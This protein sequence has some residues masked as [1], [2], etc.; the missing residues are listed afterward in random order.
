MN[1][2]RGG[3]TIPDQAFYRIQ[4]SDSLPFNNR[5]SINLRPNKETAVVSLLALR[6]IA[7]L[8]K[9]YT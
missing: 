5:C 8:N 9:K 3:G 2:A 1:L 4:Q 7:K 6:L